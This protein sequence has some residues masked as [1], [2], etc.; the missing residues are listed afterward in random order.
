MRDSLIFVRYDFVSFFYWSSIWIV[1]AVTRYPVLSIGIYPEKASMSVLESLSYA[2]DWPT[3]GW[4][5]TGIVLTL[6]VAIAGYEIVSEIQRRRRIA[7]RMASF[8]RHGRN[9]GQSAK[10]LSDGSRF[11]GDFQNGR[12][13]GRGIVTFPNGTRYEGL[14]HLP[15][16]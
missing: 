10:Q 2:I 8:S 15:V 14:F 9:H 7:R 5:L 4:T 16:A 11:D 1:G 12:M 3:V 6:A 13:H